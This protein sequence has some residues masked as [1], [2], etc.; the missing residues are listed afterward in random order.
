MSASIF[1]G[2]YGLVV[3]VVVVDEDDAGG[4]TMT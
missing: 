4:D 1:A 3:V 2:A